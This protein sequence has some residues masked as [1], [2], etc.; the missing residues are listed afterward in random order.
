MNLLDR[1]S[2]QHRALLVDDSNDIL[3]IFSRA[4]AKEEIVCDTAPDG[5]AAENMLRI[6][7]YDVVIT[8]LRMPRKHG[9]RLVVELLELPAPPMLI[10]MTGVLE[11][12]LAADLIRRGV[13]D[14]VEKPVTPNIF[15]AK[16][17][18]RL[19]VAAATTQRQPDMAG[20]ITQATSVL[21]SQ[22][23]EVTNTFEETIHDLERQQETLQ[24][25]F[26]GS[27]R[28]LRNLFSQIT[29]SEGS[30]ASRVEKMAVAIAKRVNLE[31]SLTVDVGLA[32][33][34]HD[35]GQ[36][37]MP[38]DFRTMPPWSLSP[39]QREVFQDYPLIGAALLSEV[40][41]AQNVVGLI[42]SHAENYDGSGFPAGKRKHSIPL[43]A[44]II[45]IADGCDTF[46]MHTGNQ[47]SLDKAHEHL[48]SQEGK[49][50]DPEL[51]PHAFAYLS[52]L[53]HAD[54]D[55]RTIVID[56]AGLRPGLII[57][58]DLYD[59]DGHF[60]LRQDARLTV[61]MLPRLK[62]LLGH[63]N[64]KVIA[65]T[66]KTQAPDSKTAASISCPE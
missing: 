65:S 50:Y 39:Q 12:R 43:G 44:L 5:I 49:A 26:V 48:F 34:L 17:R 38:D 64:V 45:R 6:R 40:L 62:S 18:A 27:V 60:L 30:H 28:V 19:D 32:A 54:A 25:G 56:A 66:A 10:V 57:A 41:G 15:A 14:V 24:D 9:Q 20:Q 46:L 2:A 33:L 36:F 52:E 13:M 22:L 21:R 11:P 16:V 53:V 29:R 51:V 63:Q 61:D 55:E 42:E 4:L 58:E 1:H 35:L 31:K 47:G 8:D 59:P 3:D 37:G 23:A 7:D